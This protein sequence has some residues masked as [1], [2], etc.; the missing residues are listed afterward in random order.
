MKIYPKTD[1]SRITP[2]ENGTVAIEYDVLSGSGEKLGVRT[3]YPSSL[4]VGI[5]RE[6]ITADLAKF[7]VEAYGGDGLAMLKGVVAEMTD[8]DWRKLGI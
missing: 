6:A 8:Q 4:Q 3:I 5:L 2:T 7:G 1:A